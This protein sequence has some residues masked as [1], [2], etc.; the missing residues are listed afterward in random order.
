MSLFRSPEEI[1]A[2]FLRNLEAIDES[3]RRS[4]LTQDGRLIVPPVEWLPLP[5][6]HT[7]AETLHP[8]TRHAS[9]AR[10]ASPRRVRALR[11]TASRGIGRVE[12]ARR[13]KAG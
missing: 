12:K 5:V 11:S 13:V 6:S 3:L 2:W 7:T 1:S 9:G 10:G 8:E 4:R